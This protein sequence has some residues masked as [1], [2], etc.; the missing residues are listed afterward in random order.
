MRA[1]VALLSLPTPPTKSDRDPRM[2]ASTAEATEGAVRG[3]ARGV[4]ACCGAIC[5]TG[6]KCCNTFGGW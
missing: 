4:S 6:Q 1:R 2:S 5:R 3:A